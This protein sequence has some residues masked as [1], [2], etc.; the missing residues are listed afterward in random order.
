MLGTFDDSL[1]IDFMYAADGENYFE[2]F[3]APDSL[4]RQ[5]M[6]T[7]IESGVLPASFIGVNIV[8]PEVFGIDEIQLE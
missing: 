1:R 3:F 7:D 5:E 8:S 4:F 6:L 2:V